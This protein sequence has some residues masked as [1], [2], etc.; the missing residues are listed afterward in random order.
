MFVYM[1]AYVVDV[2][3][4]PSSTQAEQVSSPHLRAAEVDSRETRRLQLGSRS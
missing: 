1:N 2:N 4:V 3:R